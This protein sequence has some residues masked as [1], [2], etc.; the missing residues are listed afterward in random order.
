MD[1][2]FN[3]T[4]S[5]LVND[6]IENVRDDIQSIMDRRWSD[7]TNNITGR[8]AHNGNYVFTH[9]WSFTHIQWIETSPAYLNIK[10]I[11]ENDRTRIETLLRPNSILVI[12]F[13]LLTIF[14]F[15]EL[16]NNNSFL[17]GSIVLKLL[18]FPFF[19]LI[20]YGLMQWFTNGLQNRFEKIMKL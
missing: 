10:L 19:I 2:F 1:I 17:E 16:F 5:Y 9:K 13:Y 20:L 3:R 15:Y 6:S 4:H 8:I 12:F 7:F 14:F 18:F 11:K